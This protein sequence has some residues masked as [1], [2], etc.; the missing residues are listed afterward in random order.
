MLFRE[1]ILGGYPLPGLRGVGILQPAIGICN[2]DAVQRLDDRTA[3]RVRV[4]HIR[5]P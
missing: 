3:L 5:L 1:G 4:T 2:L